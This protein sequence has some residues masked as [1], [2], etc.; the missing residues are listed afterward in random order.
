LRWN[1]IKAR[2]HGWLYADKTYGHLRKRL[3]TKDKRIHAAPP[4]FLT[5]LGRLLNTRP[6]DTDPDHPLVMIGR[7][8]IQSMNSGLN[9]LPSLHPRV[10][11]TALE[12][13]PDDAA[14]AGLFT[15]DTARVSSPTGS[16]DI[17]VVVTDV[18]RPGVVSAAHGWGSRVF[19]PTG[20]GQAGGDGANRNL[21]TSAVDIDPL[22]QMP[23]LNTTRVAV[24]KVPTVAAA[25]VTD[26]AVV[27]TTT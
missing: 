5:E 22:A 8:R 10:G 2:P 21:L 4:E 19:D 6:A 1:D 9:V 11:D 17:E 12:I 18:V 24:T 15:G 14:A 7:R 25:S 27:L 26:A 13:H 23:A 20:R 3:L 16:I